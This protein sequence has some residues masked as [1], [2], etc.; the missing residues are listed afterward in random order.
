MVEGSEHVERQG[1]S[2]EGDGGWGFVDDETVVWVRV[3]FAQ[4]ERLGGV[5]RDGGVGFNVAGWDTIG[6]DFE[7]G[8][9]AEGD[10]C[11]GYG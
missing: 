7:V 11:A 9:C 2:V 3:R 10:D 8:G 1:P 6:R 5:G 4:R